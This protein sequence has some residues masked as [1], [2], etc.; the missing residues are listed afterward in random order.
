MKSFNTQ[1]VAKTGFT[2]S[3]AYGLCGTLAL[4]T[5]LLIGAGSVSADETTQPVVDNQPTAAN[6]YTADNAGN[7][8]V[9]PSETVA[10][11]AE[12]PAPVVEIP[13]WKGGTVPF[14]APVLDKPEWSGGVVPNDAPVVEIPE[15]HGGTTPFD[16]PQLDKPEWS[17]GVVPFDAP[18]LD[19]PELEIPNEPEEPTPNKPIEPKTPNKPVAP[20]E[21][22]EVEST[23]VSY[24]FAPA[25]KETPKTTVYGGTLPNTGE[26]EG[27][28]STLGLVVIAAGITTLGL[29]FKKY[30]EEKED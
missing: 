6:V 15:W 14:D 12:T 10:P 3:K 4:A 5:A 30:N 17:G 11:V 1:T 16:A 21:K 23:P 28:L 26:K 8:T 20:R 7:V 22:K 13:E 19:L 29:S 18:V 27:I 25:S 2:K 24:N 9:T